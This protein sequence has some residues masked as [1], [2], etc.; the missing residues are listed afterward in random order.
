M[1]IAGEA[2]TLK[3]FN[4]FGQEVFQQVIEKVVQ[5]SVEIDL[6]AFSNGLYFLHVQPKGKKVLSKRLVVN[7]LY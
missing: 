2:V 5:P 1:Q 7:R 6:T 4:Q 3:L